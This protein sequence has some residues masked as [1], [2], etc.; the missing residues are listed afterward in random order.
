VILLRK[1]WQGTAGSECRRSLLH[2]CT[3]NMV[4]KN[5]LR[6]IFLLIVATTI[7]ATSQER[8]K[9]Y[10]G[11]WWSGAT[12]STIWAAGRIHQLRHK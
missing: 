10:D 5:V 4:G 3:N 8:G 12:E 2:V 11:T 9:S 1:I 6:V 7:T